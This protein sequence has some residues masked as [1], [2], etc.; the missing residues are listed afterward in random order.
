MSL[1]IDPLLT[2]RLSG[3]IYTFGQ[4][5]DVLPMHRHTAAD[6]H[7]T[8]VAR[9]RVRVHGPQIGDTEY[10]AGAVLDWAAGV[11]HEFI[12][13]EDGARIVNIIKG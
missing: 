7:I 5:G 6:V 3:S 10:K 4:S 12:A 9:G 2:G 13:L 8:V 11:D 1:R